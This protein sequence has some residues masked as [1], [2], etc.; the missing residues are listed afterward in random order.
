MA[1]E[2]APRPVHDGLCRASTA[3]AGPSAR[4]AISGRR[5]AEG[6]FCTSMPLVSD[7]RITRGV[8]NQSLDKG[9]LRPFS[10]LKSK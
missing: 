3:S 6:S 7:I 9:K 8:G 2:A 10:L 1:P 4:P 5:A